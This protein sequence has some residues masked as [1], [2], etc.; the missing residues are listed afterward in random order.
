MLKLVETVTIDATPA[1]VFGVI[2][3]FD[4]YARWN[5]WVVWAK[6]VAKEGGEV[7]VKA[8]L[9]KRLQAVRHRILVFRP[10]IEF[11][12]CDLGW[13]TVLAY[14]ERARF[15]DP[16]GD[17]GTTYRVELSIT[18]PMSGLVARLLGETL[19]QGLRAETMALKKR[20]EDEAAA[21]ARLRAVS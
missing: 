15:L 11:R 18:G 14:G 17:G 20:V 1:A 12:W 4:A 6:G 5:P 10:G 21:G 3:D 8:K 16:S 13:F 2:A 7:D 9:G 19:R